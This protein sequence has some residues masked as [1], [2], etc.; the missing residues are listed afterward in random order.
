[1]ADPVEVTYKVI[2]IWSFLH[3]FCPNHQ[4]RRYQVPEEDVVEVEVALF[5]SS[6]LH[7][8]YTS[9]LYSLFN[10]LYIKHNSN[11]SFSCYIFWVPFLSSMQLT[12]LKKVILL[13]YNSMK[14]VQIFFS[15]QITVTI[16]TAQPLS[17]L[18]LFGPFF[19][20][21]LFKISKSHHWAWQ[22]GMAAV[23][24]Q[25]AKLFCL[26]NQLSQALEGWWLDWQEIRLLRHN[27]STRPSI[28]S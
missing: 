14:V 22:I 4:S 10:T 3:P 2:C 17:L 25:P 9:H 13:C 28:I 16:H 26:S 8:M 6:A 21:L 7:W 27:I 5:S 24:S 12:S 19:L 1:M 18:L 20:A 15:F 23:F 11:R